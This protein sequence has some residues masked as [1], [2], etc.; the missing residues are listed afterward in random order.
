LNNF[1]RGGKHGSIGLLA[2]LSDKV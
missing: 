1:R 2:V